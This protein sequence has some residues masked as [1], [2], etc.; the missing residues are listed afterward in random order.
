MV[1]LRLAP[2]FIHCVKRGVLAHFSCPLKVTF[3]VT[4]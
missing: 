3:V 1:G 4:L 2:Q